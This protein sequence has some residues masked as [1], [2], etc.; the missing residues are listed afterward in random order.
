MGEEVGCCWATLGVAGETTGDATLGA[1]A[2]VTTGVGVEAVGVEEVGVVVGGIVEGV[3]VAG[4]EEGV[5]M[6]VGGTRV[7][8]W[9]ADCV[10]AG[11]AEG[12]CCCGVF[13]TRALYAGVPVVVAGVE[14]GVVVVEAGNNWRNWGCCVA[15]VCC[16]AASAVEAATLVATVAAVTGPKVYKGLVGEACCGTTCETV[17]CVVTTG[18]CGTI[19]CVVAT[20]ARAAAGCVTIVCAVRTGYAVEVAAGAVMSGAD[21]VSCARIKAGEPAG[22]VGGA[23]V[24]MG[25]VA[26]CFWI[27]MGDVW[28]LSC[29]CASCC[30]CVAGCACAWSGCACVIVCCT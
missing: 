12:C 24:A 4:E 14:T 27:T 30:V 19:C 22:A 3:V 8:T 16:R 15:S 6:G 17:C 11:R 1:M 21:C 10:N 13:V 25:C 29:C 5:V 2:G 26:V 9:G 18:C 7:S 23:G 28:S 20:G